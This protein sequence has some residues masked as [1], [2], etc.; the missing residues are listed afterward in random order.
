MRGNRG[1]AAVPADVDEAATVERL[2]DERLRGALGVAAL[3][4]YWRALTPA[5]VA[6]RLLAAL[7]QRP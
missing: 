7:E 1:A 2:L 5:A 4:L 3:A 6:G